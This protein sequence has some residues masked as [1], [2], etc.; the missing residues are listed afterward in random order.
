[1][2]SSGFGWAWF[3]AW[4]PE[5]LF[6]WLVFLLE[7]FRGVPWAWVGA[8]L[9]WGLFVLGLGLAS[10]GFR[11]VW[12][13]VWPIQRLVGLCLGL[14]LFRLFEGWFRPRLQSFQMGKY[15]SKGQSTSTR[16]GFAPSVN[17][18]KGENDFSKG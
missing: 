18:A 3:T 12:F 4:L 15:S 17:P 9:L 14:G 8:W 1:M 7:L 10:L 16:R 6:W 13:R 11:Q 2:S 5:G